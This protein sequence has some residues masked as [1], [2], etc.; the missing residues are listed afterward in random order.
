MTKTICV[1]CPSSSK[2]SPVFF[3][4]ARE[5]GS[6]IASKGYSL[7]YGGTRVGLMEAL[8]DAALAHDG[9]VIGVIPQAKWL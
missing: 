2:V 5:L 4:A 3:E 6:I 1:F 9:R 7:I 8:A